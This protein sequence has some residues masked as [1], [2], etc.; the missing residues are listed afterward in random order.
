MRTSRVTAAFG[1]LAITS[2]CLAQDRPHNFHLVDV[3][4]HVDLKSFE[5]TGL[6]IGD[7]VNTVALRAAP[8]SVTFDCV[9]LH[10]KSVDVDGAQAPFAADG[11]EL[12]VSLPADTT[13]GQTVKVHIFY[14]GRPEAGLY[15]VP[16]ARAFPAH[17]NVIYSQGEMV[18]NRCWLP[19]WDY[20]NDKGT[21]EGIIEVGK[22]EIAISNGKLLGVQEEPDRRIFHWKMNQPHVTYLISVVAGKFDAGHGFWGKVP[23]DYYVPQGLHSWGTAAF[24]GTEKIIDLYSK[25]TGFPYPYA[26]FCQSAVPDY[27]FG[28][29]ENITAVTQTIG[30]LYPPST[31]PLSDATGLVAHEL[32]H[33]WFGDKSPAKAGATPG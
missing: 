30:A 15:F 10:V 27:M 7:I 11:K 26:K 23:V 25:I 28:G 31:E 8:S 3:K 21:S 29:M 6:L 20:P 17:T 14:D 5:D 12:K 16:G 22:G 9:K 32:A 19:T 2:L 13:V 1:F 33:Q 24:G 18:D 4:W